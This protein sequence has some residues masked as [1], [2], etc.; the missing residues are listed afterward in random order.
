MGELES[1]RTESVF[2]RGRNYQTSLV[3]TQNHS[4]MATPI[5]RRNDPR[6]ATLIPNNSSL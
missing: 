1:S 3:P 5:L 4:P 6:R 2:R